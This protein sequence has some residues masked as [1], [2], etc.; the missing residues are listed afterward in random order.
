[1]SEEPKN[2]LAFATGDFSKDSRLPAEKRDPES[3]AVIGAAMEVH[4]ELR[5]GLNEIL[6]KDALAVEFTMQ[7]IP[8][9]REKLL[10]VIYKGGILP[11]LFKADFIC[12]GTLLRECK[13][14]QAMGGAEDAQ[15]LNY[16]RITRLSRGLLLNFGTRSLEYKRLILTVEKTPPDLTGS[17]DIEFP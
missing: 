2:S 10:T 7:G 15:V 9:E 12:F 13:A 3:F 6:Y 16:L 14:L 1:M 17:A 4:R 11:S 5:H 8:F